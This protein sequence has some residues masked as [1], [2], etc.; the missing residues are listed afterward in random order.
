MYLLPIPKGKFVPWSIDSIVDLPLC[1]GHNALFTYVDKLTKHC[2]LIP[3]FVGQG[4]LSI[5][6]VASLFVKYV[7]KLFGVLDEVILDRNPRFNAS[8]W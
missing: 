1:N 3:C 6:S 8:F 4:A 2:R 7:V 5:S